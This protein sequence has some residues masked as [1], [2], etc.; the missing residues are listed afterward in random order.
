MELIDKC[1]QFINNRWTM[2]TLY[3]NLTIVDPLEDKFSVV[4]Y[5]TV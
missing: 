5:F 2:K 1:L 4:L 3:A